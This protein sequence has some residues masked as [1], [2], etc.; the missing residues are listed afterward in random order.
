[1]SDRWIDAHSI[2]CAQCGQLVDERECIPADIYTGDGGEICPACQKLNSSKSKTATVLVTAC[3]KVSVA[4]GIDVE[5]KINE[6]ISEMDYQ[7][8]YYDQDSE[9]FIRSTEIRDHELKKIEIIN[10]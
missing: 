3:I 5:E 4:P 9:T 6:V 1:M 2:N 8:S 7:F 10:E